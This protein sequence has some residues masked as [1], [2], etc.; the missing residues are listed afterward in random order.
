MRVTTRFRFGSNLRRIALALLAVITM[1][2][3]TPAATPAAGAQ[4]VGPTV[5]LVPTDGLPG[6]SVEVSGFGFFGDCGVEIFMDLGEPVRLG[7]ASVDEEG[8]FATE[9]TIPPDAAPGVYRID[10]LGQI[11]DFEFCTGPSG[12]DASTEF[13]VL[14]DGGGLEPRFVPQKPFFDGPLP[15]GVLET[16][17]HLKFVQDSDVRLDD[18]EFVSPF[19]DLAELN[20]LLADF[21]DVDIS[22]LFSARSVEELEAE[23]REIEARSGRE[24]GDKNLYYLLTLPEVDDEVLLLNELNA[25]GIV[26]IAYPVPRPGP[27]PSHDDY[28]D[29][30]GYRLAA[31][32][33]IHADAANTVPGG[34]GEN[35]QV[36]DIERFFNPHEDLPAVTVYPNGDIAANT[37]PPYD[38]GTAVLGEIFGQDNGFG[39][40]GIAHEADAGFVSTAGGRANAIDVATAN[41]AAGDVIL[42]ELQ[43]AGANGGCTSMSQ[44]GCVA[45]EYV[46][47]SYDAIVAA[48]DA[49]IIVVAAAGNG[50]ENLDAP[51]YQT[52]F[53]DRPDSGA[54][55]V[56]AG[57]AGADDGGNTPERGRLGFSTFGSRVNLQGWGERVTTVGY[58]GLEGSPG[59]TDSY[60][61]T[62]SGTSSAS[63]IV[64]AAAAVVSSV[65]I[66]NGDAD[67]LS[68]TEARALLVATGTPQDLTGNAGNIGPLPNLAAALGLMA[69]LSVTKTADVEPAVAGESITYTLT[70]TNNGPNV[71]TDVVVIDDLPSEVSFVSADAPCVLDSGDVVCELGTLDNGDVVLLDVE[72]DVPAGL[73]FDNGGPDLITNTVTVSSTIEDQVALNDADALDTNVVAVADLEVADTTVLGAPTE[74]IIGQDIAVTVRSTVANNGPSSPMNADLDATGTPTAGAS[75]VP[76]AQ[77]AAVPALAAGAPQVIDQAFTVRCDAPGAQSVVFDTAISPTDPADTDPNASN[78]TGQATIDIE[79]IVPIVINVRPGN[80]KN[81]VNLAGDGVIN[82][83][84]LTTEAG[85]Y[86]LPV[87]FDATL[88]VPDTVH[89]G[90]PTAVF[91]QTGGA[92]PH[93]GLFH[94]LDVHEL[95]DQTKD[96]DDDMRMGFRTPDTELMVADTEACM[97]GQYLDGGSLFWFYGCDFVDVKEG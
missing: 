91:D 81:R 89:F 6:S 20:A 21:P 36:I 2:A 77:T 97:R 3:L 50:S 48:T 16:E 55:I 38:H 53:G 79:C 26:E 73:V 78:D 39:V 49:G 54:I 35:V 93:N 15:D 33:G 70:V 47:A 86:G 87:A 23:K 34:S 94:V 25:L 37:S 45:E 88:I 59:S 71:A 57:A 69:D 10:V 75:V 27:D 60:T 62:F 42:L 64:A 11:V 63:P 9:V 83:G 95:D 17:I 7:G 92:T 8:T 65:A 52:T 32:S 13:L 19:S 80:D 22:R 29:M 51:E 1:A 24:Q 85:E 40:L 46:Q 84:A 74:A 82:V 56:G 76:G 12:N 61:S 66:E 43:R 96:G 41:S 72:V 67:G 18:G 5:R 90:E 31:G 44:V 28:Q 68:S 30:Q 4:E 14:D 58:G